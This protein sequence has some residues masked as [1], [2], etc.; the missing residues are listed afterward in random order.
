[1]S[2]AETGPGGVACITVKRDHH[3]RVYVV[4][5]RVRS[6]TS[7]DVEFELHSLG[8]VRDLNE[9]LEVPTEQS[10]IGRLMVPLAKE[11]IVW[12]S[13]SQD[14][15]EPSFGSCVAKARERLSAKLTEMVRNLFPTG[16]IRS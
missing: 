9:A 5:I 14:D 4:G 16:I 3:L 6:Q 15:P 8:R 13:A 11:D 7:V 1:M 10:L 2:G 12:D